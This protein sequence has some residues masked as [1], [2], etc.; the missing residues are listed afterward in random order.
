MVGCTQYVLPF[1][2]PG[3]LIPRRPA[4]IN[5][6][7]FETPALNS[8]FVNF[9]TFSSVRALLTPPP[10]LTRLSQAAGFVQAN[11]MYNV[12]PPNFVNSVWAIAVLHVPSDQIANG[13]LHANTTSV[14]S[15][16]HCVPADNVR[17]PP[18]FSS[19]H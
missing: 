3:P 18:P 19:P 13:T 2:S 12:T 1:R 6:T 7:S 9:T 4:G 14:R 16:A 10:S 8:D 15:L 17:R 5:V 11:S